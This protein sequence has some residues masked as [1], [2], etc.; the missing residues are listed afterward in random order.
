MTSSCAQKCVHC[1]GYFIEGMQQDIDEN[2]E[3]YLISG[4]CDSRGCI[5]FDFDLMADM[6]KLGKKINVHSGLVDEKTAK[7]IGKYAD[8]VSFDFVT[9]DKV[10]KEI[11]HLDCSEKDFVD[12]Y[13]LLKKYC[14]VV[15]HI[16]I[17]FGNEKRSIDKLRELG[18][19]Q[20]TFIILTKH[21][22]IKNDLQEPTLEKIEEVLK[23]GRKFELVSLGC[24]R[25]LARKKE[26]DQVAI[27]YVDI[28]VNP[29][30]D[31]D[32]S[33]MDVVEKQMCCSI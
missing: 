4:G 8:V 32:F 33:G 22:S 16:M 30:K 28:I 12:S 7:E 18:E 5:D 24:M 6:K 13:K 3:S 10:I 9:D 2:S 1:Q 21:P 27:K 23:Y 15:P 29:H 19:H 11:Y 14:R 17:G 20:V 25:P 26:I 31:V